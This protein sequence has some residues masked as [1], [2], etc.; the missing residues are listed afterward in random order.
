M[1]AG[2]CTNTGMMQ[3]TPPMSVVHAMSEMLT[4][5]SGSCVSGDAALKAWTVDGALN[6][7]SHQA[8]IAT[9]IRNIVM[10]NGRT[11]ARSAAASAGIRVGVIATRIRVGRPKTASDPANTTIDV[12]AHDCNRNRPMAVQMPVA[13]SSANTIATPIATPV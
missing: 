10:S 6:W 7:N 9:G 13:A 5:R 4:G 1:I 11:R 2:N 8:P 3:T 12:R